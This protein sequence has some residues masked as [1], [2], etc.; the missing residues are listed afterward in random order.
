MLLTRLICQ[1]CGRRM[2]WGLWIPDLQFAYCGDCLIEIFEDDEM[3]TG[4]ENEMEFDHRL[5]N[6][7]TIA[8]ISEEQQEAIFQHLRNVAFPVE[9]CGTCKYPQHGLMSSLWCWRKHEGRERAD[10]CEDLPACDKY[11][12]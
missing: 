6:V 7:L 9:T 10:V 11:E 1:C 4:R 12:A 2:G 3:P 5:G 8:G